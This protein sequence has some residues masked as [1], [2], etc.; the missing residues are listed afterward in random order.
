MTQPTQQDKARRFRQMHHAQE[1]LILANAWD[2]ASA[3]I[4]E[5]AGFS[6]IATTSA[7]VAWSLGYADGER[8]PRDEMLRA[9]ERIARAVDLPVSADLEAGYGET[10]EAVAET[11]RLA[12]LAGAVGVNF[13]DGTRRADV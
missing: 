8:I 12:I 5:Q 13:E 9:V 7:G 6:A 1:I 11:M 4:I 10:L 3:K 2:V